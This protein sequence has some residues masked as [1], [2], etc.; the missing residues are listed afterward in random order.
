MSASKAA[1][2]MKGMLA[3]LGKP[4]RP[5]E[6]VGTLQSG[7]P[8]APAQRVEEASVQLNLRVPASVKH[9]VRVLAARDDLTLSELVTRALDLYEQANGNR[10]DR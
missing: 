7:E 6:I 5:N 8:R 4:P 10:D 3:E 1:K 2:A 9:R